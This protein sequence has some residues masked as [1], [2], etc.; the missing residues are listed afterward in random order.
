MKKSFG[1]LLIVCGAILITISIMGLV[2]A[3]D[4]FTSLG[5]DFENVGYVFGS[6]IFPLLLTVFGRWVF[7]KGFAMLRGN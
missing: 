7:R 6:I 1:F 2:K 5:A 3:F 4:V